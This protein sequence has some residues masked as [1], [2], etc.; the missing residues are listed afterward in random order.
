MTSKNTSRT[1][2]IAVIGIS[3][4]LICFGSWIS[5][6]IGPIPITLQM[7]VIPLIIFILPER[8]SIAAVAIFLLLGA[9]GVPVFSGFKGGFGAFL[10]PT[11]GFLFGY[12]PGTA[13]AAI[14]LAFI[15]KRNAS[16][17]AD[18]IAQIVCGMLFTL[19]AY[20]N[21]VIQYAIVSGIGFEAAFMVAAAPF[22]IPD[23]IKVILA[24]VCAG[25]LSKVIDLS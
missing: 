16:P 25:P 18:F 6:P 8:W 24:A 19:I 5:I 1:Y 7:F 17:P 13:I 2:K 23:I 21:G 3:V 14:L 10:G 12:I 15:R 20:T 4:A 11:G 22:I 9:V